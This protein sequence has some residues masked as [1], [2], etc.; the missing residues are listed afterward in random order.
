[1]EPTSKEGSGFLS[2][3]GKAPWAVITETV[4]SIYDRRCRVVTFFISALWFSGI[5]RKDRPTEGIP[6]KRD[7][8]EINPEMHFLCLNTFFSHRRVTFSLVY[9][10]EDDR[11]QMRYFLF[12][13]IYNIQFIFSGHHHQ[14]NLEMWFSLRCCRR[15]RL[16]FFPWPLALCRR[17]CHP[18][19][20]PLKYLVKKRTAR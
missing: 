8:L 7:E 18:P 3:G 15:R 14:M 2:H 1:M 13:S 10:S 4:E 9:W 11:F 17:R 5:K 19:P 12:F 20:P 16:R 6:I